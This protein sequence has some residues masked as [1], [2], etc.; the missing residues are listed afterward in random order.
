MCANSKQKSNDAESN[1]NDKNDS[2]DEV[3][4]MRV[5]KKESYIA[6]RDRSTALFILKCREIHKIS[7]SLTY[8]LL[9]DIASY[10]D[11]MKDRLVHNIGATLRTK[12]IDMNEELLALNNTPDARN[13]FNGLQSEFLQRQYFIKHF[14]LVVSTQCYSGK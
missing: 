9:G 12:G 5:H 7:P 11:M 4:E 14:N 10:V 6:L 8:H 1:E 13:P 2:F 3:E